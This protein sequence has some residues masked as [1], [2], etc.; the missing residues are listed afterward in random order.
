MLKQM[1]SL[2][3]AMLK[4]VEMENKFIYF[5]NAATTKPLEGV[6]TTYIEA[7][8]DSFA[9][10]S[11]V[12]RMGADSSYRL[13]KARN[14]IAKC[15]KLANHNVIFTSGATESNNLA[16]KGIT[17]RY[18]RNGNHIITSTV[19]HPSV[20]KVFKELE[21]EG[22]RVSYIP[23]D[24]NGVIKLDELKKEICKDTILVSIMAVNN[25]VGA[26]MPIKEMSNIIKQNSKAYF[27]IDAVQ[28]VGKVNVNYNDADL[29]T[30]SLHKL[31]GLK[32]SGLLLKRK[33]I[34]LF[35][36]LIGGGQEEG[37][38]SGTNDT[39]MALA[40]LVAVKHAFNEMDKRINYVKEL[41][42]PIYE[43]LAKGDFA[44]NSNIN[45]PF[46]ISFS[47]LNKKA[48]VIVEALAIKG[49]MV[50]SKSACSSKADKGSHVLLAMGKNE[51]IAKNSIRLSLNEFNNK[52]EVSY[53]LD[54]LTQVMKEVKS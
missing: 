14:D 30:V 6:L 21:N 41:V 48:S 31:G 8:K 44:I 37:L 39:P 33:G 25:E 29:I 20:L 43:Y 18:K 7:T 13:A 28:A 23:V 51:T 24:D 52:E 54:A 2:D 19:E 32:S 3:V 50:A 38:R 36:Q 11:S 10:P 53:F 27:H 17:Y 9:N 49:V 42:E 26:I 47:T 46:I 35:P 1:R 12:H 40:S 5:D 16:I 45:N 22:F 4:R 34:D 15:F